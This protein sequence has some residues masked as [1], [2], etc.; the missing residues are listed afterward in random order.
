MMD[1]QNADRLTSESGG[2]PLYDRV[3][4]VVA[5]EIAQ[6]LNIAE[7]VVQPSSVLLDLG[8]Q[9]LD[10]VDLVFRLERACN[11]DIPRTFLLPDSYTIDA[12][13]Q[14]IVDA[15]NGGPVAAA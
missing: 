3:H 13:V 15:L 4:A 10:F 2:S 12:L 5:G 6:M 9:S 11:V 14:A 1:P 8:A 7:E